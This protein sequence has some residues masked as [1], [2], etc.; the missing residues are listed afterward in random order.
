MKEYLKAIHDLDQRGIMPER[1]P[2]LEPTRA[3]LEAIGFRTWPLWQKIQDRQ[4]SVIVV[5]GTNGKG[6]TSATLQALLSSA[7]E[8]VGLY[9]SPHLMEI[10]ERIRIGNTDISK[11]DF[12]LAHDFVESRTR[13]LKLSHFEMLTLMAIWYFGSGQLTPVVDRVILEVGMGGLWDATNAID[14][15]VAVIASLGMDHEKYLGSTLVEIAANKFGII[16]LGMKVFHQPFAAEVQKL[17]QATREKTKSHWT[18]S[19]DPRVALPYVVK[20]TDGEPSWVLNIEGKEQ[21]INLPG[22]RGVENTLLALATFKGLGY[23]ATEHLEALSKVTWPGRMERVQYKNHSRIYLSGD[24]NAQ[25]IESLVE[26]ISFYKYETLHVVVG[27][28]KEKDFDFILKS[29]RGLGNTKIYLTET[30]FRGRELKDY[31]SALD[32]VD[33]AHAHFIEAF[34]LALSRCRQQDMLLV[35]GS[36]YLVGDIRK[37]ITKS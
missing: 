29:L 6:S 24:H 28:G 16:G 32:Q 34:N 13:H 27:V 15:G 18:P 17:A 12:V 14:H 19:R 23:K 21:K 35:T 4:D 5:A 26:L 22:E 31:G 33:E 30:P 10:T 8:R 11:S 1:I 3:G 37:Y 9:T 20:I 25:G 36:L 2:S 7:G